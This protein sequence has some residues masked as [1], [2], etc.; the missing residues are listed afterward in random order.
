MPSF[1]DKLLQV[2]MPKTGGTWMRF[3]LI[4][5]LG[6][7]SLMR[8][9]WSLIDHAPISDV[10]AEFRR[11]RVALGTIRDPW[12]W[13]LSWYNQASK[14][15]HAKGNIAQFGLGDPSFKAV[16]YG[17]THNRDTKAPS[18]MFWGPRDK[19]STFSTCGVGL[20]TWSAR[21]MYGH[22]WGI[23]VLVDTP[24]MLA[25]LHELTG[26]EQTRHKPPIN[27]A[28]YEPGVS[29]KAYDD[30]MIQWVQDADSKLIKLMGYTEPGFCARNP[31]TWVNR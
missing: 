15:A 8:P 14:V 13:Y 22:P 9:P 17:A 11:G 30:E 19:P 5:Q 3:H 10:P 18:G 4:D 12:S 24:Q 25:A 1:T 29:L 23:N 21:Y 20:Y 6:G 31:C 7:S 16:L 26:K 27:V 2:H 28:K